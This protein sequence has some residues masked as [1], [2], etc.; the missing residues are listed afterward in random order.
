[1]YSCFFSVVVSM[2]ISK[3]VL[4]IP[5]TA[6]QNIKAFTFESHCM[7][8]FLFAALVANNLSWK[9]CF[10]YAYSNLQADIIPKFFF[11]KSMRL[12]L[13]LLCAQFA[14][15]GYFHSH[16]KFPTY[17]NRQICFLYFFLCRCKDY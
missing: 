11:L 13:Y 15:L 6:N 16:L 7:I 14:L 2:G 4:D 1:M 12:I 5:I 10:I 3:S 9:P 8:I 17:W